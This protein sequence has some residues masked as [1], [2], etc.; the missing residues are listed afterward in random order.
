METNASSHSFRR[1]TRL[2]LCVTALAFSIHALAQETNQ[3]VHEKT[4]ASENDKAAKK[5]ET[6]SA[7]VSSSEKTVTHEA[8]VSVPPPASERE[9]LLKSMNIIFSEIEKESP[10]LYRKIIRSTERAKILSG[11]LE[12]MDSGVILYENGAKKV[13]QEIAPPADKK[14]YAAK[15]ISSGRILYIRMDDLNTVSFEQLKKDCESIE[16]QAEKKPLGIVIDLRNATGSDHRNALREL[17]IFCPPERLPQNM[18]KVEGDKRFFDLPV[19]LLVGHKTSGSAEIF[20]SLMEKTKQGLTLGG[21]TAGKPF[22]LKEVKSCGFTLMIPLVPDG[23]E[24]VEPEKLK[25]SV[26]IEPYPQADYEKLGTNGASENKD[27]C[28]LRAIDLLLS[29]DAL[30]NKWSK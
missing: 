7:P 17:S 3:P 30:K 20:A 8:A 10:A 5:Q 26:E 21:A 18:P 14:A 6:E 1:M 16:K 28:L 9:D 23:L 24:S 12:S 15:K 27:R 19:M 13:M 29:L 22:E 2:F 4:S 11:L 25:P